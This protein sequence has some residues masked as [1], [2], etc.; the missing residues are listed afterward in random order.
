MYLTWRECEAQVR[1]VSSAKYK[2]FGSRAEAAEFLAVYGGGGHFSQFEGEGFRPDPAASF[3][4]EFGRL[5]SSQGWA[6]GSQRYNRER[7]RALHNELRT[8]YFSSAPVAVKEEEEEAEGDEKDGPLAAVK[9]EDDDAAGPLVAIKEEEGDEDEDEEL[10]AI[11][12]Q[13]LEL[14]GFQDLCREIGKEPADTVGRCK[15]LLRATLVNIV[16]LIDSRRIGIK[17]KVWT[18]FKKFEDYTLDEDG[19]RTM[20]VEEAKGVPLLKCF[21]KHFGR[22]RRHTEKRAMP[23]YRK[24]LFDGA[25]GHESKRMRFD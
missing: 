24:R 5:S 21:L 7:A 9:K 25:Y 19:D 13:I 17:V 6:P 11:K 2:S 15:R 16:D 23:L 1:G 3:S 8:H 10:A 20:P 14:E 4:D 22:R 12:E 18:D